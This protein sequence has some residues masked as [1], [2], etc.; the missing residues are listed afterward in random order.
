MPCWRSRPSRS[1]MKTTPGR[2][3]TSPI[4]RTVHRACHARHA[5]NRGD[6]RAFQFRGRLGW[7]GDQ[8]CGGPHRGQC[9]LP[10]VHRVR[11]PATSTAAPGIR[12]ALYLVRAGLDAA[13]GAQAMDRRHAHAGA[14]RALQG[15]KS[16]LAAGVTGTLGRFESGD[17]VSVLAPDGV[18]VARGIAA[19]SDSDATRI[20]GRRSSEIEAILG[21]RGREELIHRDDLVFLQH[22]HRPQ[23]HK[24]PAPAGPGRVTEMK[25]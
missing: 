22:D 19:Y 5:R 25:P 20:M 11:T 18:E 3:P 10:Y 16:L 9:R 14:L 4:A 23:E 8:D 1:S 7:H 15:G 6:G 17:T 12:G 24:S 13:G 2:P 21:F